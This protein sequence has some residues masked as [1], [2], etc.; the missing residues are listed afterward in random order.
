MY[1]HDF[2]LIINNTSLFN[3]NIRTNTYIFDQTQAIIYVVKTCSQKFDL[4]VQF[5]TIAFAHVWACT[6]ATA[7]L[8]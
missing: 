3:S 2:N 4:Y 8:P 7:W 1:D 6:H 5:T